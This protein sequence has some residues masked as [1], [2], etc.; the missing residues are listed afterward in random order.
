MTSQFVNYNRLKEYKEERLLKANL[1]QCGIHWELYRRYNPDI[2]LVFYTTG[3]E[4]F[5]LN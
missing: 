5:I 3:V 1:L 4:H 2:Y